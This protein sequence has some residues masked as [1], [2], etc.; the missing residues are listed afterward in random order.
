L[1]DGGGGRVALKALRERTFGGLNS[2][3][4]GEMW[5]WVEI[6]CLGAAMTAAAGQS[7]INQF[8][9]QVPVFVHF[10]R[11]LGVRNYHSNFC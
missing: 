2:E 1:G 4:V 7:S 5:L 10:C 8:T 9:S 6:N 11:S 3:P